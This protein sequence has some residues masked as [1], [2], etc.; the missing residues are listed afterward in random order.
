MF[1][2]T[3]NVS[4]RSCKRDASGDCGRAVTH[5]RCRGAEGR[6]MWT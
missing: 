3:G 1:E 2:K 5:P 4:T 6:G